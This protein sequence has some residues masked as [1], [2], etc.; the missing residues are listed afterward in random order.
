MDSKKL[1]NWLARAEKMSSLQGLWFE[2]E[3]HHLA[4]GALDEEVKKRRCATVAEDALLG[5]GLVS[6]TIGETR[7]V[8]T[9]VPTRVGNVA[10]VGVPGKGDAVAKSLLRFLRNGAKTILGKPTKTETGIA[11]VPLG[12]PREV[13]GLPTPDHPARLDF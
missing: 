11:V 6:Y 4:G 10:V 13:G 8:G 9:S 5:E 7:F 12:E 2:G 1:R 3:Y